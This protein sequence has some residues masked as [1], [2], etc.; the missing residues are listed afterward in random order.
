[1]EVLSL[2]TVEALL[3]ECW[4]LLLAGMWDKCNCVVVWA[5]FGIAFLWDWKLTFSSPV[6]NT[7]T[8]TQTKM[9]RFSLTWIIHTENCSYIH[10]H[11]PIHILIHIWMPSHSHI[12]EHT[13]INTHFNKMTHTYLHVHSH[14][15]KLTH[16]QNELIHILTCS[17]TQ[18]PHKFFYTKKI[19]HKC[20]CSYSIK[21]KN[22]L[23][24][25]INTWRHK[26]VQINRL[27]YSLTWLI[28]VHRLAHIQSQLCFRFTSC[29]HTWTCLHIQFHSG[30]IIIH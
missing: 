30:K 8:V 4:T 16:S 11:V 17:N 13:H 9:L 14:I 26:H 2:S 28:H 22:L 27:T 18:N 5:F 19:S 6:E 7:H 15:P 12:Y 24:H 10:S 29:S 23:K 21:L 25:S 20:T 3:G 1:M